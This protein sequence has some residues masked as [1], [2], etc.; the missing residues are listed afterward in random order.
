M[1]AVG[2]NGSMGAAQIVCH[3]V[4]SVCS[5]KQRNHDRYLLKG[6]K[7]AQILLNMYCIFHTA[8]YCVINVVHKS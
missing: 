5:D 4:V 3:R 1:Q 2:M 6:G 8:C 7:T